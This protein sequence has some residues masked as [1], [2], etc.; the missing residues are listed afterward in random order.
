MKRL[1]C[2]HRL[3]HDG[4]ETGHLIGAAP[5]T[6]T[7]VMAMLDEYMEIDKQ[8]PVMWQCRL[9]TRGGLDIDTAVL[10]IRVD[11]VKTQDQTLV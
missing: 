4:L 9:T 10:A 8:T 7:H 11:C 5:G 2:F 1:Q 3:L 6:H